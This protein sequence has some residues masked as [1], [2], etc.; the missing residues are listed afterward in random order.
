MALPTGPFS[1]VP[2][3]FLSAPDSDLMAF[4]EEAHGLIEGCPALVADV[5]ADLDAPRT[6]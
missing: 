6:A 2:R 4:L 3:L 1:P 5:E